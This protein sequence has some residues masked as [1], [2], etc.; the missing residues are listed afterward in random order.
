MNIEESSFNPGFGIDTAAARSSG[1]LSTSTA[2]AG[3][4]QRYLV[5]EL[6][7]YLLADF[8]IEFLLFAFLKLLAKAAAKL[9]QGIQVARL[10]A[11][12]S[13]SSGR[14]FSFTSWI[15]TSNRTVFPPALALAHCHHRPVQS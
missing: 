1:Q 7:G 14:T 11:K 4:F 10:L 2:L 9:G 3:S 8:L 6:I 5:V 15:V 12:S 13:L